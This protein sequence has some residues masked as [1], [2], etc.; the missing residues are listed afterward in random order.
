MSANETKDVVY[1]NKIAVMQV[2]AGLIKNP[3]L[4]ANNKYQIRSSY[5]TVCQQMLACVNI[6]WLVAVFELVLKYRLI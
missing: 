3:L 6:F 4:F 2:L 1:I 5:N